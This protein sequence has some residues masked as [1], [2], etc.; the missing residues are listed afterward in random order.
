M[1]L[2]PV[3]GNLYVSNAFSKVKSNAASKELDLQHFNKH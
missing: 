1:K 2:N 3:S